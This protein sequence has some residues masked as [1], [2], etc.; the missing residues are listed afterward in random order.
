MPFPV[1]LRRL[2][3][4]S[5]CCAVLVALAAAP[6]PAAAQT[7]AQAAAGQPGN[8]ANLRTAADP[9][10]K[11]SM[12]AVKLLP[13][14]RIEMDGTLSSPAWQRA[15][16]YDQFTEK[17]PV[18]GRTPKYPTRVQVMYDDAAIYVGVQAL[19]DHPEQ[20]RAPLV[21]HDSVNRTQDFVVVYVDAIGKRQAAQWFRVNAAGSTADGLHTAADDNEDFSPDYDF[22]AAAARNAKGYTAV[23]RIPFSSL[24]FSSDA[25]AGWRIMVGRRLPR[26]QVYL[27]T[28]V[29]VPV[30]APSFIS[31]MQP[32]QDLAL[33]GA[34]SFL[35][36]RPSFTLRQSRTHDVG[37][38]ATHEN[39]IDP[40]LDVKWHPI[41]ELVVD[42]TWKP[43]F[44][45][46]ALDVPQLSGNSSFA[47]YLPEKRPF[48]FESADLLRSPS[49][50]LYTRSFTTPEWGLR[51]TWRGQHLAGTAMAIDD[52]G[53]G[54]TLLP[55]A[56]GTNTALQPGSH[57]LTAR[58]RGDVGEGGALELGA[59]VAARHYVDGRGDNDVGG[60]DFVWN[61]TPAI[62]LRGQWLHSQTSALPDDQ[63]T[64]SKGP[65]QDG[66]EVV[67]KGIRTD[68]RT[69]VDFALFD[70]SPQ[71]RHDTGFVNQVGVR[72][73]D[74]HQGVVFRQLGAVNELWLNLNETQVRDRVNGDVVQEYVTPG[75][76]MSLPG[77]TQVE[78]EYRGLSKLRTM[79]DGPLLAEHYW[80]GEFNTT[81]AIWAPQL[82]LQFGIGRLADYTA[83]R[84]RPGGRTSLDLQTRPLPA[85]ELEPSVWFNWLR[86]DGT[87]VYRESAAQLLGVYHLDARQN[88]RV[89]L[90]R[91]T[92]DHKAEAGLGV[93]GYR[94]STMATSV[95]Y[96][97]RRSMGTVVYVGWSNT[98]DGEYS[99]D[100]SHLGVPPSLLSLTRRGEAFVKVQVDLD[101]MKRLFSGPK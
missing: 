42:G 50:A 56:Y 65:T 58:V 26:D 10:D 93:A 46:V 61:V 23:F 99:Q 39:A 73:L 14:E 7:D 19:D 32:M 11:L 81:P 89:I 64:L 101:E 96:A 6:V 29:P 51:G 60:P 44:S 67:L 83:S 4:L 21:R 24:R 80:H 5:A 53:N 55:Y 72:E 3:F 57:S 97:Y 49:D 78:G 66:D 100:T 17:E 59:L 1:I 20:L 94:S 33:P 68:D 47:L 75:V 92:Y 30:D 25:S 38:P 77:N 12:H 54:T 18:Y 40:T 85:L 84:V 48:F 91:Y 28:S 15:P 63:G 13:D 36:V 8:A 87:M 45:Q 86:Q 34:P 82:S 37:A 62:R 22:D 70:T 41:P 71:F 43:D 95:T 52:H 69:Q 74:L 9:M 79:Q 2:P 27:Y 76:W 88:V 90:Q 35:V 98:H 16:V 31:T